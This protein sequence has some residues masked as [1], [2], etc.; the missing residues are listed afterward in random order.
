[1]KK[2]FIILLTVF[3][4]LLSQFG[5]SELTSEQK[6][7][8]EKAKKQMEEVQTK[9]KEM[10]TNQQKDMRLSRPG[11]NETMGKYQ[12]IRLNDNAVFV[13]DILEGH[14]WVWKADR[15][16]PLEYQGQVSVDK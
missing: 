8:L 11:Y 7:Q 4:L 5:W 12:A 14:M 3:G 6:A 15:Q 10:A 1:M 13:I 2:L 9:Q 16:K